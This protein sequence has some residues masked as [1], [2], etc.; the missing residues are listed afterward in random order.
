[1]P[2]QAHGGGQPF[3]F[4]V[5]DAATIIAP[6]DNLRRYLEIQNDPDGTRVHICISNTI[7]AQWDVGLFLEPGATYTISPDNA[8]HA[9]ITGICGPAA[10]TTL[11][12]QTGY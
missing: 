4:N 2:I 8:T 7:D 3:T 12:G 10:S 9:R 11:Y 6:Q 5:G 1:M